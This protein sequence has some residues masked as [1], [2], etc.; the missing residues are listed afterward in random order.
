M[1]SINLPKYDIKIIEKY[2]KKYIWDELRQKYLLL[3]PEEWVRQHFVH[4]LISLK[5]FPP[6]RT[7]NEVGIA[8]NGTQKRCD[9]VVYDK[10][11]DPLVII[12]YK[13]PSVPIS[14]KVFD[15]IARYNMV[16]HVPYLIIS[17]GINHYCCRVHY[18][19]NRV[20]FLKDI[21]SYEELL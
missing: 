11:G 13:R 8:L 4:F 19:E 5:K 16:L 14:Q 3:T 17:N 6:G 7:S 12:E 15:Q 18:Q 10:Y 2:K 1:F 9:T 21:P 20:E